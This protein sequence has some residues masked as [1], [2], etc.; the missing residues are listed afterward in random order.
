MKQVLWSFIWTIVASISL[1]IALF[2]NP[3]NCILATI[4]HL[5]ACEATF[6]D[7]KYALEKGIFN[8]ANKR[9]M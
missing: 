1:I 3:F 8:Y 5:F 6:T 4:L 9:R 2:S 7:Y